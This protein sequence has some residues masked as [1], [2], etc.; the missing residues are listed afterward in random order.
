MPARARSTATESVGSSEDTALSARAGVS[1]S[2]ADRSELDQSVHELERQ[3]RG[4]MAG[5]RSAAPPSDF[6]FGR[7]L[8]AA[9]LCPRVTDCRVLSGAGA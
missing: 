5:L 3:A 7:V 1:P 2:S 8:S 4:R 6:V 9:P